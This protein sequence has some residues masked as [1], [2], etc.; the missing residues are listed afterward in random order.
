M[1][2]QDN[3]LKE[4]ELKLSATNETLEKIVGHSFFGNTTW[5]QKE[6]LNQ[7]IDSVDHQLTKA[8]V[9]LRI[10]QDGNQYIQTLK[11]KGNS[12]GGFSARDEFDWYLNTPQLDVSLLVSPYWPESLVEFDKSSLTTIFSTNFVRQYA[13]FMWQVGGE[14][15][16]IEVAID[17][18]VVQAGDQQTEICELELELRSGSVNAMLNCALELASHYPLIPSSLSKAERGYRLI[19]PHP[20]KKTLM[21][22]LSGSSVEEQVKYYVAT[23]QYYW[24]CYSWQPDYASLV[25]WVNVLEALYTLLQKHNIT[26]LVELLEPILLDWKQIIVADQNNLYK[27]VVEETTG[28]RLGVFLLSASHWLLNRD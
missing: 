7:Y 13:E 22:P 28:T 20:Y 23:S 25:S 12:V 5:Q 17:Q 19:N 6:L 9:A 4:I 24:E 26:V 16:R 11:S 27:S 18:G 8:Q 10:R 1:P 21:K 15:A 14:Q 3:S 2:S